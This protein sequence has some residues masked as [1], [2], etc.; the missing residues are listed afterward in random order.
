MKEES[1]TIDYEKWGR[2][3]LTSQL[4]IAGSVCLTEIVNNALLY[5]TRSQG[6]GPDTIVE[7]LIRYLFLTTLINFGLILIGQLIVKRSTSNAVNKVVLVISTVLICTDVCYSHYQFSITLA[8]YVIPIMISILYEDMKLSTLTFAL[9]L[10]GQ[11]VAVFARATDALYNKDIGPEAAIAYMFTVSVYIFARIILN[12]LLTRRTELG[13]ALIEAEKANAAEERMKIS[14][15]MLETLARAIDAKDKYT[16]G[17]SARVAVYATILA[18]ALGWDASR[19]EMLKYEALLHDIGKIGVPDSI[20]NKPDRL[21]DTEFTIIKS[22]TLVGA[23]ILKDMAIIPNAMHVAKYHH[24]RF[25]GTGYPT[26][27]GGEEIPIDARVVGIA[28][29]YDAMSSDRIYRKALPKDV[30]REELI[31]GRGTQFDPELLDVFVELLDLQKLD[32]RVDSSTLTE[33]D[34]NQNH[35]IEDIEQVIYNMT[36]IESSNHSLRYFD[37]FYDYM[38]HIGKRYNRTIEILSICINDSE[39]EKPSE[40]DIVEAANAMELA[41][42]KNIRAVD[43]YFRESPRNHMVILLDAGVENIDVIVQRIIFD[44]N[45]N[46]LE[47]KFHITSEIN[48]NINADSELS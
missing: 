20:L 18:E 30:I 13:D 10:I 24:E 6:Y 40:Q 33:V 41:V 32:I 29:A 1:Y 11:S 36:E 22:H 34:I 9:S 3:I 26:S 48:E 7:K 12:T 42:K 43:V 35:V 39:D 47:Y 2:V 45:T 15:K 25:D 8:I 28:D 16:N 4:L 31:K 38:R 27:I 23:D 14:L 37:K 44:F 17:H 21:T 46:D 5:I 19:I